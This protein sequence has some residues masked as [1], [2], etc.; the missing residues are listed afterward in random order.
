MPYY[1]DWLGAFKRRHNFERV[2]KNLLRE[3]TSASFLLGSIPKS[4]IL[5]YESVISS[6][7]EALDMLIETLRDLADERYLLYWLLVSYPLC[8]TVLG[9]QDAFV[10][11]ALVELYVLKRGW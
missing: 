3:T 5:K 8:P 9:V 2:I 11:I 6:N 1:D 10:Q 4:I 7:D